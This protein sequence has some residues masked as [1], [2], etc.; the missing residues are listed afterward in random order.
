MT[1]NDPFA[2]RP[3]DVAP[4][5]ASSPQAPAAPGMIPGAMPPPS[6]SPDYTVPFDR[7]GVPLEKP[8]GLAKGLII[9][10][11]LTTLLTV[12]AALFAPDAV[13]AIRE[14]AGSTDLDFSYTGADI[15]SF[16]SFPLGIA[17]FVLYGLWMT[18]MRRNREALGAKPGLP[19]VEWWGWFVPAANAVLVPL[20]A[21][22]VTGRAV[23]LGLLLGWWIPW[24]LSFV[25]SIVGFVLV[26]F[27][28]DLNTGD[29]AR[30]EFLDAYLG[31]VWV[32]AAL[33]VVSFV[34]F[35]QFIRTATQRHL[36]S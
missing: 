35:M 17:A 34:F 10:A 16:F 9:V 29:L 14:S 23:P 22:K 8:E 11:A 15:A 36:E 20:G 3:G 2:A 1:E 6:Y 32:T 33:V 28:L 19:A 12:V 26:V 25:L 4:P 13:E 27:A 7:S 18:R 5:A 24:A 31:V 30:P 21:R